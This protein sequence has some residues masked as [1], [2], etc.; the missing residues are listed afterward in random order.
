M[1][2]SGRIGTCRSTILLKGSMNSLTSF[3]V[4][5]SAAKKWPNQIAI[6][7]SN[8]KITYAE[9][10]ALTLRVASSL[11]T[12]G[13][14][15]GD[16]V[17]LLAPNCAEWIYVALGIHAIGGVL[18]PINTRMK[19]LEI[20]DLLERS[21]A[22][23]LFCAN[24]FLGNEFSTIV[25]SHQPPTLK[26]MISWRF[27]GEAQGELAPSEVPLIDLLAGVSSKDMVVAQL[28]AEKIESDSYADLMFTSG[29]TGSPK[30]VISS[31]RQNIQAFNEWSKVVGL[32]HDDRYLIVNPFF[33]A[34]GYKAGWLSALIRGACIYPM[35]I[36]DVNKILKMIQDEKISFLPGPPTLFFSM[37]EHE[38]L[39]KFDISSLRVAVTG[40][41]TIP[42]SLIK[43]MRDVLQFNIVTTAYGL[44]ECSG[45]AT[46][47]DP[48]SRDEIIAY[49]SGKALPGVELKCVLPDGGSAKVGEPGEIYIRGYNVMQ[50]YFNDPKATAEAIDHEGWLHTGDIGVLDQD[51]N[52]RITDRLKNMYIA[53]GF[54]CYPA[55]IEKIM[56]MHEGLAQVAVVGIPDERM[57][58][59]GK[60][61]VVLKPETSITEQVL[62]D[63]C[64]AN[65]ANYKVPRV[66]QFVKDFPLNASGKV[67]KEELKK[68]SA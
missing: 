54:N 67:A 42:P 45:V 53:G 22:K 8:K 49:T 9:L 30:G 38:D 59:V 39:S 24:G 3:S 43:D 68:I 5:L 20:H 50:G 10:L 12:L 32:S 14:V 58:E 35:A 62:I 47:C 2:S 46:V 13:V 11:R 66:V 1:P 19:A 48:K 51:G 64:R 34:F 52:L 28:F 29:T 18:L 57:G 37:I 17:A 21:G 26:R 7:E 33:H 4:L 6:S 44:T 65:M 40:A 27:D 25:S 56:L 15:P 61:F 31:H 41:A 16:R 63:W 55:E 60:A 23:V 36:F